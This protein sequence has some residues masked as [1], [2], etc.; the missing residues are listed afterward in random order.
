MWWYIH[1][2]AFLSPND[3][4]VAS[5]RL[6][7]AI[8]PLPY[9]LITCI[10]HFQIFLQ[11]FAT[12]TQLR[13]HSQHLDYKGFCILDMQNPIPLLHLMGTQWGSP[14]LKMADHRRA[15][16]KGQNNVLCQWI[17]GNKNSTRGDWL[18]PSQSNILFGTIL[19][20]RS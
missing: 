2:H 1:I 14:N 5:H 11:P 15:S 19:H 10:P 6:A 16:T 3:D 4:V 17:T 20:L 8:L 13:K 12:E 7:D 18:F 9:W